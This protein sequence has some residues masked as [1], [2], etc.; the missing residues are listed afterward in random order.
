MAVLEKVA[1]VSPRPY[2]F[3]VLS[4][5]GQSS[6]ATFRQRY[7]Y[8]VDDLVQRLV[9]G[10][11]TAM[12]GTGDEEQWGPVNALLAD[13]GAGRGTTARVGR[14]LARPDPDPTP[15][16]DAEV[17]VTGSGN[18]A[19][20]YLLRHPERLTWE[21]LD[22]LHPGLVEGLA[23]HEGVGFVVVL[24]AHRGLVALGADGAHFLDEQLVEGL[25]PLAP[26][27]PEAAAEVR[28][29][30]RLEHVGDIVVNSRI[31]SGTGEVAAFEELVGSHGGLGGWQSEAVLVHPRGWS[32]PGALVGAD[33][34]HRQLVRWLEDLGLRGSSPADDAAII[35]AR[36]GTEGPARRVP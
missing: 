3:V 29:H 13:V 19:F 20:V 24:S 23:R 1:A 36:D 31:D 6:G 12:A 14:R 5:H 30:G 26:Y 22:R 32:A 8:G 16:R 15:V 28:R 10:G 18:L 11:G 4:D 27:G 35:G 33:A 7:G 25:D 34:V 9:A 21:D 17:V 2:E